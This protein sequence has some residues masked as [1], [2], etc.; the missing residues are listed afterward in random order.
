[1]QVNGL[2]QAGSFTDVSFQLRRSEILGIAGLI[3]SG[4]TELVRGIFGADP[5]DGGEVQVNGQPLRHPDP[6]RAIRQGLS[7]IPED[8]KSQGLVVSH[9]FGRTSRCPA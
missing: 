3:G 4:R 8:R 6:N 7:L 1:M 5:V 9:S 2:T